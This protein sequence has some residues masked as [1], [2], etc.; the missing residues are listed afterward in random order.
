MRQKAVAALL[1]QLPLNRRPPT[2]GNRRR[3]GM[4]ECLNDEFRNASISRLVV[5]HSGFRHSSQPVGDSLA[6][7]QRFAMPLRPQPAA[8]P[9]RWQTLATVL[10]MLHLFCLTLGLAVN[11]GGGKSML[12]P[13]LRRIPLARQYLQLL[14]MDLAYDFHLASPLP[15]DGVHRLRLQSVKPA[16][17]TDDA[18]ARSGKDGSEAASA[19]RPIDDEIP[20]PRLKLRIRRQRYQQLAYHVAF[21]DELFAENSD[22]RTELP[23]AVAER[24]LR[25]LG[26]PHEPYVFTCWREPVRR[27]PKAIELAP[28]KPREGGPRLA[29]PATFEPVSITVHLVWDPEEGR[30]QG[31]RAEPE[32]QTAEVVPFPTAGEA[33]STAR[34]A[35]NQANQDDA[36]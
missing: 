8:A 31:S 23:L 6:S 11:A 18:G 3:R 17:T 24:W 30:Y 26:A 13:A 25:E 36:P 22:L 19:A 15:E 21:F 9:P 35:A 4:T 10:L 20:D 14:W 1:R 32:G 5:R 16:A 27:L 2:L 7:V 28:S 12:G 29:G 34:D 33:A